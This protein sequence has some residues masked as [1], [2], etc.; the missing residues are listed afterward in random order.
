MTDQLTEVDMLRPSCPCRA[1]P[2]HGYWLDIDCPEHGN[3]FKQE[4]DGPL[5][6]F[7]TRRETEKFMDGVFRGLMEDI[8]MG[9][10]HPIDMVANGDCPL[11]GADEHDGPCEQQP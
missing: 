7:K 9:D 3:R 5:F 8:P 4:R 1:H 2:K 6:E 11:C 10:P